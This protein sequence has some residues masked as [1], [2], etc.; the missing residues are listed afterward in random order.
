MSWRRLI[1][2][3]VFALLGSAFVLTL[4]SD[5]PWV[6]KI[7]S[8]AVIAAAWF[9]GNRF[10]GS[11]AENK[12]A[13]MAAL[14]A[15]PVRGAAAF[16]TLCN[17]ALL[18]PFIAISSPWQ[19]VAISMVVTFALGVPVGAPVLRRVRRRRSA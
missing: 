6:W 14:L 17:L 16:I 2:V 19:Q 12:K 9:G 10:A 3:T 1:D 13:E 8:A 7:A 4:S 15:H 18:V 5:V 11:P